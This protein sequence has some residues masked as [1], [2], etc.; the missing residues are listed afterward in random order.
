MLPL[1]LALAVAQV[2]PRERLKAVG[3]QLEQEKLDVERLRGEETTLL[4]AIDAAERA[5]GQAERTAVE[6]E[7]RRARA[8]E[9][10]AAAQEKE[11]AARQESDAKLAGLSPRLRAWQ[12]LSRERQL[13]LLLGARS[14]QQASERQRLFRSLLGGQLEE[15]RGAL[16][17]LETARAA[18]VAAVS[19]SSALEQR[20]AEARAARAAAAAARARHTALL[21]AVR[22][23]RA[24]HEKATAELAHAQ[25]KL[26]AVVAALPPQKTPSTGFAAAKGSLPR[27]VDGP[28]EVGFGEILNPRF[29]T[30]TLQ[31][32]LDIRAPEGA[33]VRAVHQGRVVHAG[34]LQGYGNLLIVDHGDGFYTLFA[35]L[36][37]LEKGVDDLVAEGE[38]LGTVGQTGSLK[39]PYLYFEIRRHGQPLDPAPWFA[40]PAAAA[41]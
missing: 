19:L 29:N 18:R 21:A 26:A 13:S 33:S 28:I 32:G 1:I 30:V 9:S 14:A 16:A 41:R 36:A 8:A 12:R 39:G 25:G 7:R 38:E 27:P 40:A 17:A 23:E 34:W 22:T 5:E 11:R 37:A 2:N 31:K 10:V 3:D 4:D 24:L 15:L 35:H 20:G 6:A